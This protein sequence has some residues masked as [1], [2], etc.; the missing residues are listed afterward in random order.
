MVRRVC[1]R[2]IIHQERSEGEERVDSQISARK[3]FQTEEP[4]S[5]KAL[6][7]EDGQGALGRETTGAGQVGPHKPR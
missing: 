7:L 5:T 6:G 2:E 4:A 1:P 3:V